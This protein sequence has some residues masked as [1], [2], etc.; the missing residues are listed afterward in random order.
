MLI[1]DC[2]P[3]PKIDE[4]RIH[5]HDLNVDFAFEGAYVREKLDM[6]L[7]EAYGKNTRR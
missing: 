6:K 3:T 5:E 1:W 7:K 2:V 4:V